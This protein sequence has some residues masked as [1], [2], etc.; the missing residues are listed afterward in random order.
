MSNP[1]QPRAHAALAARMAALG[2]PER[3]VTALAAV[4]REAFVP[5]G[6]WRLA[7]AEPGLWLPGGAVLPGPEAAARIL[8]ALDPQPEAHVVEIGTGCGYLAALL[9]RLAARVTTLDTADAVTA[10]LDE[11]VVRLTG[12]AAATGLPEACDAVLV[13]LPSPVPP[14][15]LLARAPR[16]VAVQGVPG[17]PQ[18]LLLLRRAAAADGSPRVTDLGPLLAAPP[19]LVAPSLPGEAPAL[20]GA[21]LEGDPAA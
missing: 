16:V 21:P 17:G 20:E 12:A 10:P 7:H 3:L 15:V 9:A 2:L 11:R 1:T 5:A 14:L 18:R 19:P 6:L 13:T 8:A 4:P